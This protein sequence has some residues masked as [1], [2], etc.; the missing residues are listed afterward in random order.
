MAAETL[1]ANQAADAVQPQKHSFAGVCHTAFGKYSI[2]ANVED[3]DIFEMCKLPKGA[4]VVGGA[5]WAT[6]LDDGS[7]AIDM[8]VGWADNG[9]SGATI[10]VSDGTE[11]T[12]GGGNDS[13]ADGFVNSGVLT[14]DVI[15]DLVAAGQNYRPFVMSGGPIY[16][17]EETK[18]QV[19]ANAAANSFVAGTIYVRVDYVVIG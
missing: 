11:Y 19:E 4:L 13:D 9:G 14:G 6:D 2:A 3:G 12:N 7:E 1:T 8:D 15:T 18:V 10:T 5:F 17:S 16:F